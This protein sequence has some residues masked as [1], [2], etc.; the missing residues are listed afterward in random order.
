[1]CEGEKKKKT[2]GGKEKRERNG[3]TTR[4]GG[5][6]TFAT[7]GRS[8]TPRKEEWKKGQK[9]GRGQRCSAGGF[10]SSGG[11]IRKD[12]VAQIMLQSMRGKKSA[13]KSKKKKKKKCF[14]V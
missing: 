1:V 7:E 10:Q 3:L 8:V 5:K 4:K 12:T 14:L 11:E 13:K 6:V 2:F 9:G